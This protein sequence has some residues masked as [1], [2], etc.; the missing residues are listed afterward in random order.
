MCRCVS[1]IEED[2]DVGDIVRKQSR[3]NLVE[4]GQRRRSLEDVSWSNGGR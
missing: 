1:R 4:M 3:R 2:V